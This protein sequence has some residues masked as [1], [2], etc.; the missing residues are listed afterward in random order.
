[1]AKVRKDPGGCWIW[2]GARNSS[3][4]GTIRVGDEVVTAY[5]AAYFVH[6][7]MGTPSFGFTQTCDGP[8]H[9]VNPDHW[10]GL[11]YAH[12]KGTRRS[13]A[14]QAYWDRQPAEVRRERTRRKRETEGECARE[15]W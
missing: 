10:R 4:Y 15:R 6:K 5:K 13:K 12:E 9:C 7:G 14:S 11:D 8:R 1:M 3:G 2:V